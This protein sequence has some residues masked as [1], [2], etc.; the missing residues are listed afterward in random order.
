M[1]PTK[2]HVKL[3]Q[4]FLQSECKLL[5]M[6]IRHVALFGATFKTVGSKDPKNVSSYSE[7]QLNFQELP[8]YPQ[9]KMSKNNFWAISSINLNFGQYMFII[10]ATTDS[11]DYS[12]KHR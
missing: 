10:H 12:R 7:N 5:D 6:G 2:K 4:F 9:T 1:G 3:L 11:D 8:A